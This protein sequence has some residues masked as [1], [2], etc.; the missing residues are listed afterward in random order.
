MLEA[1]KPRG[2]PL[3]PVE[4]LAIQAARRAAPAA[5]GEVLDRKPLSCR[6]FPIEPPQ[7]DI[8]LM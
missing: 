3:R 5:A 8:V 6:R 1:R 7:Y 4:S 2:S